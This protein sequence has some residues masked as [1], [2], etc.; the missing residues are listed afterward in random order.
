M[1]EIQGWLINALTSKRSSAMDFKSLAFFFLLLFPACTVASWSNTPLCH[2]LTLADIT[3]WPED[4]CYLF[5]D[6]KDL[7]SR[8]VQ[9]NG[10]DIDTALGPYQKGSHEY[11]AVLFYGEWCPFSRIMQEFFD[12]LS[13]LFPTIHHIAVES[14]GLWP[15]ELSQHGVRSLP[16]LFVYKGSQKVQ[17]H[18]FRSLETISQFYEARTGFMPIYLICSRIEGD[19]LLKNQ[20]SKEMSWQK[21]LRAWLYNDLYLALAAVFLVLRLL[22]YLQPK[23]MT[24]LRQFWSLKETSWKAQRGL[25]MQL[26]SE[27]RQVTSRVAR[28][29]EGR[30][31]KREEKE[32]GKGVLSVPSWPSSSLAAVALAECSSS[33]DVLPEATHEKGQLWG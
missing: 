25:L 22:F 10:R 1:L 12:S 5:I 9:I 11:V 15:S 23:I 17:F 8:V 4:Q 27:Q 21:W 3:A 28:K 7:A 26:N 24:S 14:S 30:Y 20:H 33:R 2:K 6:E 13:V 18:G 31:L 16:A 19:T 32:A 29:S